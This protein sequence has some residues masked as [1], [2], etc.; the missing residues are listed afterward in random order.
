MNAKNYLVLSLLAASAGVAPPALA[1]GLFSAT[2]AIIAVVADEFYVGEAEG[3]AGGSGTLAIHS[4]KD[5]SRVCTGEFAADAALGG[6][7]QLRCND[8]AAATFRFTRL[9]LYRG[10]GVAKFSGGEMRFAYGL[11][12]D[13]AGAYLN[14]PAGKRI[15]HDGSGLALVDR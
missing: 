1:G 9:T 11:A 2:S 6:S 7:G 8:G 10:Y 15:T 3:H 5:P 4:Q 14:L 12:P 13:E